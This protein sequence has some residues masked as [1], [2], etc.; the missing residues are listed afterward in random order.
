[1]QGLFITGTDTGIGKTWVGAQLSQWLTK[2][3]I[4]TAPRKPA[5]SGCRLSNGKLMPADAMQ[6]FQA[7]NQRESLEIICPYRFPLAAAPDQAALHS[8]QHLSLEMLI[9]AC[10]C[11]ADQFLLV[12]GAGGFYSPIAEQA[13]NA[14]L[15][16]ALSLPVLVVAADRL[17]CQNHVLLTLEA[18]AQRGLKTAAVILNQTS[19]KPNDNFDN[20]TALRARIST[21]ILSLAY[22][23]TNSKKLGTFLLDKLGD[24]GTQHF[25]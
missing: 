1:M 14:D 6:Y 17:G 5:E 2:N 4:D 13:L 3:N 18:I 24:I 22:G 21:P 23:S 16:Q 12:E 8:G 20:E 11:K 10:R 7:I 25:T 19:P 9:K 15:A